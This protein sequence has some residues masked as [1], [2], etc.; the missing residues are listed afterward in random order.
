MICKSG[1]EIYKYLLKEYIGGGNFGEV[2]LAEDL[3]LNKDCAV[4]LLF[5]DNVSI[6]ERL[7][8]AKIGNKLSHTNLVN[9]KYADVINY[10]GKTVVAIAMP[11]YKNGSVISKMNSLNFLDL[12]SSIQCLIDVLR[13]L[14]YLHEN[15]YYHCDIKPN[16]ILIGNN[17]EFVLSD[18]GITCYSPNHDLVYPKAAYMLHMA[19]EM[20]ETKTYDERT[21][22]YQLGV[23]A[24][25][26]I[27]GL[28]S[29]AFDDFDSL[30]EDVVNGNFIKKSNFQPYIPNK[31]KKIILKSINKNPDDRYQTALQMRRDLERI[32]MKG[33]CSADLNGNIEFECNGY[34]YRYEVIPTEN[35]KFN[36]VVYKTSVK[37]GRE[38][39]CNKYCFNKINKSEINRKI[40]NMAKELL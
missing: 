8:E 2:W 24:Y 34:L 21:D 27:N 30:K 9:I 17:N 11:Y 23:T 25:R 31:L 40:G 10:S 18:Y 3:T 6:D 39:R 33:N 7:L 12:K 16:N 36:F 1:D 4:K 38:T 37:T 19:S 28:S 5:Q 14:E 29:L 32:Y 22:I 26:L 20:F 35:K 13:G 15:G